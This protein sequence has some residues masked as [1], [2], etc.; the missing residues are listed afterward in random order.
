MIEGRMKELRAEEA[1]LHAQEAQAAARMD[2]ARERMPR[3]E[4][5]KDLLKDY[6][7]GAKC[8]DPHERRALL[9]DLEVWVEVRGHDYV[10]RG[11]VKDLEEHGRLQVHSMPASR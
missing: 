11:C 5:V 4:Q 6:H 7:K 2:L 3:A 10:V 8:E 9:E 1:S